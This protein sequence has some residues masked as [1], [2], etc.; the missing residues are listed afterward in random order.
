MGLLNGHNMCRATASG[1]SFSAGLQVRLSGAA[2]WGSDV[3]RTVRNK[4]HEW[5]WC[6]PTSFYDEPGTSWELK[7]PCGLVCSE[8]TFHSKHSDSLVMLHSLHLEV[9]TPFPWIS[10][11]NLKQQD[12]MIRCKV[13]NISYR[14]RKKKKRYPHTGY[15]LLER[16][17][18]LK[19]PFI[20]L[21]ILYLYWIYIILFLN[22]KGARIV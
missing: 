18:M 15:Y 21:R 13:W 8:D 2:A 6:A 12:I 14:E 17:S 10:R 20:Q 16:G 3:C 19:M 22:S 7:L 5:W 9:A 1:I 4:T 11:C